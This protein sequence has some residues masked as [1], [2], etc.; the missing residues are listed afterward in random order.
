MA[1]QKELILDE[2]RRT[3]LARIGQRQHGRYLVDELAD[4]TIVL[5]PAVT[6]SETELN[7][8]RNPDFRSALDAAALVP[9]SDGRR[10]EKS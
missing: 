8:L 4:G 6:I 3:S 1:A 10:R 9:T 2:R 5:H 7:L